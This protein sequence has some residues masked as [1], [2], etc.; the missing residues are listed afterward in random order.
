[1][2]KKTSHMSLAQIEEVGRRN[3]AMKLS[4]ELTGEKAKMKSNLMLF[5]KGFNL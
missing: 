3:D 2:E 5:S 4:I 1:M